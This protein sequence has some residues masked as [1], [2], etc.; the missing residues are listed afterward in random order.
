[1]TLKRR[2]FAHVYNSPRLAKVASWAGRPSGL[3]KLLRDRAAAEG[4]A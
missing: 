3:P 2:L 4:V 1:M